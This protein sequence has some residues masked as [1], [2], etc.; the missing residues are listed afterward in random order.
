MGQLVYL[1]A[2]AASGVVAI[3]VVCDLFCPAGIRLDEYHGSYRAGCG[4][5]EDYSGWSTTK[6]PRLNKDV[7]LVCVP[8]RPVSERRHVRN[9]VAWLLRLRMVL[10]GGGSRGIE[11]IGRF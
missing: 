2:V 8:F 6:A 4:M 11:S 3:G 5:H 7:Q 10:L 1:F 9:R